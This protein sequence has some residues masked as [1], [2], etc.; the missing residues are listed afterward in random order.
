MLEREQFAEVY[1]VQ[2]AFGERDP[3]KGP[4]DVQG[5]TAPSE[6]RQL[7]VMVVN[8]GSF[9]ITRVEAQFCLGS[10]IIQH[11]GYQ[12]VTG[13]EQ[14][15]E[16]LRSG[17]YASRE[18]AVRGVLTPFDV[19]IRFET[20]EI[21]LRYLSGPFPI[22]RWTDRWGTRWEHKRGVVRQIGDDAPWEP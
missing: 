11:D 4:P 12:R 14:V 2:V 7:A 16:V 17:Y 10:S 19:G 18:Q 8:R 20:D 6:A 5:R 3:G 1:A 9:T 15:P 21:H 22:V 13:F